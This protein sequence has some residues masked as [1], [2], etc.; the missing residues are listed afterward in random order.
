MLKAELG[1]GT[2]KEKVGENVPSGDSF[3]SKEDV[4]IREH[5]VEGKKTHL[6]WLK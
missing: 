6:K 3:E 1:M 5:L 2:S 4:F